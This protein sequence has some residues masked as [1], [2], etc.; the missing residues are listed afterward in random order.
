MITARE[1]AIRAHGS[2]LYDGKPY[3]DTHLDAVAAIGRRYGSDVEDVCYLHDVAEDT[4]FTISDIVTVF[5]VKKGECVV[6]CT[7]EDGVNRRARKAKTNAKLAAV[8]E[9]FYDA[10]IAKA[11]DRLANVRHSD[12]TKN[13]R[14]MKMYVDEHAEFKRAAYRPGLCD[15]LW[16][17][18]D[19]IL[20]KAEEWV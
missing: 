2:Q 19:A 17:E 15:E 16:D 14:K 9:E 12:T 3:V 5:G 6:I 8:T 1:F 13:R 4:D 20:V 18:M 7:D 11:C 10:L